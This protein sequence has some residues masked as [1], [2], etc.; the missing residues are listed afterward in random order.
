MKFVPYEDEIKYSKTNMEDKMR[1]YLQNGITTVFDVGSTYFF[2]TRSKEFKDKD[3]ARTIYITGP[4]SSSCEPKIY[5][6][7]PNES[8]FTLTKTIEEGIKSLQNQLPYQPDF[9]KILNIAGADGISVEESAQKI[10]QLLNLIR[11]NPLK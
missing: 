3:F 8:P 7:F 1:R 5:E 6:N 2:L 10:Y 4:L 11:V 9:I